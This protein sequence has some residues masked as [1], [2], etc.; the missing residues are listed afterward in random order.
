MVLL[1]QTAVDA[2]LIVEALG[3]ADARELEQVLVSSLVFREKDLVK[4]AL[5]SVVAPMPLGPH[6]MVVA[7]VELRP[8]HGL[9]FLLARLEHKLG[10]PEEVAMV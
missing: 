5:L 7:E 4:G 3:V 1:E 6:R 9:E 10:H 8:H 2:R